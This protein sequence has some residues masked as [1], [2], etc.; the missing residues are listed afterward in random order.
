M[1]VATLQQQHHLVT[2][3][4]T[5]LPHTANMIYTLSQKTCHPVTITSSDLNPIFKIL[6][7]L[8]SLLNFQQNCVYHYPPYIKYRYVHCMLLHYLNKLK[9]SN[10]LHFVVSHKKTC[11]FLTPILI[12][13]G[14][15]Y[16]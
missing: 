16:N 7:L 9:C 14:E 2:E 1:D 5:K 12:L 10:L 4:T 11:H 6:S 8:E 3:T 15:Q 13:F